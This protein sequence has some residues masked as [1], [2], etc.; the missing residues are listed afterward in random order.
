VCAGVRDRGVRLGKRWA[1]DHVEHEGVDRGT[2]WLHDVEREG[3]VHQKKK[4]SQHDQL[5]PEQHGAH[6][7]PSLCCGF[8]VPSE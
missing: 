7:A 4:S 8:M 5:D 2:Y 3:L 6:A 1:L